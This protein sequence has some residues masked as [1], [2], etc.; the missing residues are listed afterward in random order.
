MAAVN[1]LADAGETLVL[2]SLLSFGHAPEEVL[3]AAFA[4]LPEDFPVEL[5]VVLGE[6]HLTE[7][8]PVVASGIIAAFLKRDVSALHDTFERLVTETHHSELRSYA[9]VLM[10]TSR[11]LALT[12]RVYRLARLCKQDQV[13]EYLHALE[14]TVHSDRDEMVAMLRKRL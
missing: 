7:E 5:L 13:P 11:Q 10:A 8:R 14:L 3:E 4:G 9:L 2:Y 12:E 6:R 1:L